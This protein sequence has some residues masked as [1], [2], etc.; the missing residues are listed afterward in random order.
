MVIWL[1]V[2]AYNEEQGLLHVLDR[3]RRQ[4]EAAGY[5]ARVVVVDDGSTDGTFQAAERWEALPVELIRHPVNRGLG[6]SIQD[7]LSA[8]AR[9]AAP[10]DLIVTMDADNTHPPELIPA[11]VQCIEAGCDVVVASRYRRGSRVVGLGKMRHLLCYG[12]RF[13]YQAFFPA[14]GLRDY[15]CGFRA[16]RAETVQ[17][18][19]QR[20][21]PRPARERG[22]ASTAEILLKL[23]RLG[24]RIC[25]VP[26]VLR[27]DQKGSTSKMRV[28][29]TVLTTL[30]LALRERCAGWSGRTTK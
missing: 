14:P 24:A 22:F 26:M 9:L 25:E 16:Y 4:A 13:L 1:A 2:A 8:A 17:A 15:T 23:R 11:M 3:F 29:A 21:G 28:A 12:A 20:Y 30:R 19:F 7:A 18:L 5:D 10:S 27:Y 6:E